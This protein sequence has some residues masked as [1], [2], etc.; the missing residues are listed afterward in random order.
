MF[1]PAFDSR[2]LRHRGFTL[3]ELLVSIAIMAVMIAM[4]IPA[5]QASRRSAQAIRCRANLA[6]LGE[7]FHAYHQ[8]QSSLPPGSVDLKSPAVAEPSRFVWGW[9]IQLLPHLGEASRLRQLDP[10][11]GVLATPNAGVL[12]TPPDRF[13][14]PA[15]SSDDPV[16]YAGCHNDRPDQI[17]EMN[18][19][20]LMLNRRIRFRDLPDGL[21]QTILLG[22]AVEMRWAEGAYGS[23][24]SVGEPWGEFGGTVRL[25]PEFLPELQKVRGEIREEVAALDEARKSYVGPSLSGYPPPPPAAELISEGS[26]AE[27]RDEEMGLESDGLTTD[28]EMIPEGM[29]GMGAVSGDT[30]PPPPRTQ[31]L[32]STRAFGFWTAHIDGGHFLLVDGSVRLISRSVHQE[33][34]RRLANRLDTQA[35]GEF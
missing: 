13:Q 24:R 20:M 35:P 2:P 4:T 27:M 18:T 32:P 10:R 9:A 1:A 8:T 19:G 26:D 5:V 11:L 16:G 28:E 30:P 6:Q 22:E 34:L 23:L 33:V 3:I 25:P 17:H 14:C 12:L 15:S 29:S 31:T 7:A 21:H